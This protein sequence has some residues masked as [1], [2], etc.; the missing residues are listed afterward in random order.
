MEI[1][2]RDRIA[3]INGGSIG[4][5]LAI[6][7]GPAEAGGGDC[8]GYL[9]SCADEHAPIK[10][11]GSLEEL[12]HCFVFLCFDK[13]NSSAGSTYFVDGGMLKAV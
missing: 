12:A 4:I 7:E 13:A 3:V 9:E 6:T 8:E 5:R 10:R 1:G 11:F 2:L